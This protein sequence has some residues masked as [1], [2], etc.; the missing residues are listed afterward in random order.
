MY[1]HPVVRANKAKFNVMKK[2]MTSQDIKNAKKLHENK[3]GIIRF[4][5]DKMSNKNNYYI[6]KD[7]LYNDYHEYFD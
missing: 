3:R 1:V 6:G 4:Q 5:N 7:L 2:T